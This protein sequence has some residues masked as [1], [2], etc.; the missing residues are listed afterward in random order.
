MKSIWLH[1]SFAV[2]CALALGACGGGGDGGGGGGGGSGGGGGGANA[3][4][5]VFDCNIGGLNA[6]MTMQVEAVAS[7]GAVWGPGPTPQITGV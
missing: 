1:R 6:V 2:L 3:A 7:S 5:F 4:E